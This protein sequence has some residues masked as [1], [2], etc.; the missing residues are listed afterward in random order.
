[1]AAVAASRSDDPR[2]YIAG[3]RRRALVEGRRMHTHVTGAAVFADISGFTPLTEALVNELG[4]QRGPEELVGHID[5]LFTGVIDDLHAYGGE[6]LYFSGDAITGWID[7]DDGSQAA[8]CALHMQRTFAEIGTITT[9][10]GSTVELAIKV[11]IAVGSARRFVVGDPDIQLHDVLAGSLI[12]DLAA[13][14]GFAEKG[15]VILD[16]SALASLGDR[17]VLSET[18]TDESGRTAG[19]L[20]AFNGTATEK[21]LPHTFEDLDEDVVRQWLLPTVYDRLSGGSGALFAELRTAFPI[22]IRFGG[23]DFDHDED[24]ARKLDEFIK[25][26]QRALHRYGGNLLQITLGDKGAYLFGVFG[27]PRA[28]EDD[29]V[30]AVRAALEVRELEQTTAATD[31]QIG[32]STGRIFSGTNGHPT[33]R[34]FACMGDPTNLAA[35]LMGKAPAGSIY[36]SGEAVARAEDD[37]VWEELPPLTLKGKA[38]PVTAFKAVRTAERMTQRTVRYPLPMVGRDEEVAFIDERLAR[39][40]E[41]DRRII[42]ISAEPGLGK[43]R[44]VAEVVRRMRAAGHQVAFGEAQAFGQN[45]AYLVWREPWQILFDIAGLP[46]DRQIATVERELERVDPGLVPRAPLLEPLLG[47]DIPD[48]EVTAAFDAK[49][50]KTS[51]ENL[52]AAVL[53]ARLSSRPLVVVLEDGH[54]IDEASVDLLEVLARETQGLPILIIVAFRPEIDDEYR[55]RIEALPSYEELELQELGPE[56]IERVI[57]TKLEQQF[58]K[59]IT[60]AQDV[61]DLIVARGQGNPFYIEELVNYLRRQDIDIAQPGAVAGVELP[62]SLQSLVLSRVDALDAAPRRTLK[63]ASVIGREFDPDSLPEIYPELGNRDDILR[64]LDSLFDADLVTQDREETWIFRHAVTRE[65]AYESIPFSVRSTI[66]ESTG[67]Y[68][69]RDPDGVDLRLDLLAHHYWHSENLGKKIEY[70]RRAGDAAKATYSNAAAIQ[71][72]E[73]L[74]EVVDD[75]ERA[76]ALLDLGQVLEII[77][78]WGRAESVESEALGLA[79][80]VGDP[81]AAAWCEVA[82]AEVFRKQQRYDDAAERLD[83]AM[84]AF[85]EAGEPAG[86]GRVLHLAGTLASQQGDTDRA[87]E[88]YGAS[89][90]IRRE[91]DDRAAMAS[92]LSNLGVVAEQE[93]DLE[94]ARRFHEEALGAR[95]EIGDRWAIAVSNTNLGMIALLQERFAEARDLFAEAIRLAEEVGDAWV[96]A[97]NQNNIGNAYRGLRESAEAA[98]NYAASA[99]AYLRFGDRWAAAFL[100]EDAAILV[101]REGQG[102]RA[103]ELLGAADT[104]REE[105]STPRSATL[106]DEL[107]R[108]VVDRNAGLSET[109]QDEA[110]RRG[111]DLGFEAALG[112]ITAFCREISAAPLNAAD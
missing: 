46:A 3:D 93:G 94:A 48:N 52:V 87:K 91:L 45:T 47:I 16:A 26:S 23:M 58:G 2:A 5:R 50:R 67:A 110:R 105:I 107:Q 103:I 41:G 7:G 24:A 76:S 90:E 19:V 17:A 29:A 84:A 106:E 35:R 15:D 28:H 1:M 99:Q 6:V 54:W 69:E 101:A 14:E 20:E 62:Q 97:I 63:V 72:F 34:T 55:A 82:L 39:A 104:L 27:S 74:S 4:P 10:G 64:N 88:A 66:H 77:G 73:R 83:R 102:S 111:R 60:P 31:I 61:I 25:E 53:R 100:L 75:V 96:L 8:A 9:T 30:R 80:E 18:R 51:L 79:S 65:V 38:A 108:R 56:Q 70:Q 112:D 71:Y 59:A 86:K 11:A 109:E 49:L 68:L 12:D 78:D 92:V 43:S 44:L 13:A 33:R 36:V 21:R 95:T 57:I 40:L 98:E 37:F 32:V 89:L 81:V 85:D 42:G 22:F